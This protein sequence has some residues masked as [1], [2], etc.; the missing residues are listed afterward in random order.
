MKK[1]F[2]IILG[3]FFIFPT[4]IWAAQINLNTDKT[5][6]STDETLQINLSVDGVLDNGQV[7]IQGLENFA[8]VGQ[9]SS[10]Q[11]QIINGQTTAVQEKILTLQ[12]NQNGEFI[13]QAIGK[14]SGKEI[15]S[16]AIKIKVNKSLVQETKEK[17]LSSVS[18]S[19]D[20]TENSAKKSDKIKNLLTQPTKTLV[21][22]TTEQL[23]IKKLP[24][25]PSVQHFS[26]FN[27]M[28]WLEFFGILVLLGVIFC[29]I[30]YFKQ[31]KLK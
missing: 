27:K 10:Q 16:S 1:Y 2:L 21:K 24:E 20:K 19:E 12:P 28:F 15:K 11:V 17:L 13:I 5:E 30:W 4:T 14:E 18:S 26:A 29:G 3:F 22:P 6:L 9:S 23:Q 7:G 31:K 25:S 8:I